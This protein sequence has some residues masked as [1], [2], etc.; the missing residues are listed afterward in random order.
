MSDVIYSRDRIVK[1]LHYHFIRKYAEHNSL[2]SLPKLARFIEFQRG[3]KWQEM[4]EGTW[5]FSKQKTVS[6]TSLYV[7][8]Y[9]NSRITFFAFGLKNDDWLFACTKNKVD[10]KFV[11]CET[12][13]DISRRNHIFPP[14]KS[15]GDSMFQR[16]SF[17][18]GRVFHVSSNELFDKKYEALVVNVPAQLHS[19][20]I[21]GER[22]DP[23][24][25]EHVFPT[26]S[27]FKGFFSEVNILS[28]HLA[29][30]SIYHRFEFQNFQHIWQVSFFRCAEVPFL[31]VSDVR[32]NSDLFPFRP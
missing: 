14:W 3:R 28:V 6:A 1:I 10:G 4:F 30:K 19:V 2:Q 18:L 26:Y 27:F 17:G 13:V 12:G 29:D 7:P 25:R 20:M 15:P 32:P 16:I 5:R 31:T 23:V 11:T 21:L 24:T 8:I 22:Y 9:K